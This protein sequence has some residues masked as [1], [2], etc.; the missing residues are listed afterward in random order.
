MSTIQ[1]ISIKYSN[2]IN[3]LDLELIVGFIINK[4]REFII[5]HP[6]FVLNK[7]QIV[8]IHAL[9]AKRKKGAPLAYLIGKK[10]FF[11]L[12]FKVD[13]NV[14]IPRPET[15]MMVEE[16]LKLLKTKNYQLKT[17]IIDVGTGSGNIII[18]VVKN[19]VNQSS[20]I[21]HYKFFATDISQ[22]A[23]IFAKANAKNHKVFNKIKFLQ[24]NLMEPLLKSKSY[25][26]KANKLIIVANLPYVS[27]KNYKKYYSG[28]KFEPQSALV[29]KN[30][31]L[32]HYEKLF[33]QIKTLS[34]TAHCSLI[35]VL[36]EF[37]PEQKN[38]IKLLAKIYFPTSKIEFKKDLAKKWR[39][40]KITF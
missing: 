35:T 19:L 17:K 40:G 11:G 12:D 8:K 28:I 5:T 33:Q 15:E 26:L 36:I 21:G 3:I 18:S 22:K 20:V 30:Y 34:L 25:K 24:G 39:M 13:K 16:S 29:S 31:G 10:E 37:S 27:S 32:F 1:F 6:E 9:V 38:K 4:S 23:L 2:E 7:A 14:L